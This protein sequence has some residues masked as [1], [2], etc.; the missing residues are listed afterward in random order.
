MLLALAAALTLAA[1]PCK[2][3]TATDAAAVLGGPV[4][5]PKAQVLGLYQSCTY[6]RGTRAL[7]VQTRPLAKGDFAKSAKANPKPV[8]P[9]P[10]LGTPAYFVANFILLVWRDGT[11]ATFSISGTSGS[12]LTAE[13]ALAKKVLKRI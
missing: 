1:S 6:G 5:K 9:V 2:I 12:P 3:V 10:G 13:K 8:V 4:G 7:T 11:E